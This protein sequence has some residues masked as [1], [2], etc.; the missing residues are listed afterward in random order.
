MINENQYIIQLHTV[1][2]IQGTLE[3]YKCTNLGSNYR[4]ILGTCYYF[5]QSKK[6]FNDAK[7]NCRD[8]FGS[9]T[10]GKLMEPKTMERLQ[11]IQELAKNIFGGGDEHFSFQNSGCS[12]L[13]GAL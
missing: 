3:E 12:H 5:E 6:K 8:K 13:M 2:L 1:S 4:F 7:Q 11:K 10:N 9:D